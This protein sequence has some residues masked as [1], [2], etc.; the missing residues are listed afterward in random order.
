MNERQLDELLNSKMKAAKRE[1]NLRL[2]VLALLVLALLGGAIWGGSALKNAVSAKKSAEPAETMTAITEPKSTPVAADTQPSPSPAAP[3]PVSPSM[4]SPAVAGT[5]QPPVLPGDGQTAEGSDETS[6]Q[7]PVVPNEAEP[8]PADDTPQSTMQELRTHR[9]TLEWP[10]DE[11]A[12]KQPVS[13]RVLHGR[14]TVTE[15]TLRAE[16][17]W[18]AEWKDLYSADDLDLQARFPDGVAAKVNVVGERFEVVCAVS[19][20]AALD[21]G[22]SPATSSGRLPQT[23]NPIWPVPLLLTLGSFCLGTAAILLRRED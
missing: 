4:E 19:D 21:T 3:T 2:A 20:P 14:F 5:E 6:V 15:L 13:V 1:S 17:G 9:I 12:P 11:L 23:G 7:P 8:T 16:E 22:V 18:T 10:S